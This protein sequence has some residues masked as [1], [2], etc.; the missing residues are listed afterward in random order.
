MGVSILLYRAS[1][2]SFNNCIKK[3]VKL[4]YPRHLF[5]E[6]ENHCF[7]YKL[8]EWSQLL[9][10]YHCKKPLLNA[11][12]LLRSYV[13]AS[14]IIQLL[15]ALC[16]DIHPNPGP[17]TDHRNIT[18]CHI[19][20]RSIKG[21]DKLLHV[22]TDLAGRYDVIALSETWLSEYDRTDDFLLPGYQIPQ[23]R[24]RTIG[25]VGYGG[26]MVWV[27]DKIACKRRQ[28][29]EIDDIEA[30]WLE[31]RSV[32]KKFFLCTVYRSDSNTDTSFWEKLQDNIDILQENLNPK[33]MICG[34]LN[35]DFNTRHGKLLKEF[36][37]TNNYTFHINEP[38]RI[39]ANSSTILDQ[40]ITNFPTFVQNVQVLPPLSNSDHCLITIDCLF[41]IKK[42][43]IIYTTDVEL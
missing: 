9:F 29:L 23:R 12:N 17:N 43:K 30:M 32:N 34:D 41:K 26:V 2:G 10:K 14:I 28:D 27:S 7:S 39:T 25:A 42:I 40:F 19:N 3:C 15:L 20:I 6:R 21:K 31:I 22:K 24:D 36:V 4:T 8:H 5:D 16:M 18:I 13:A 11:K 1:I 37:E 33:I 38:T 35:A